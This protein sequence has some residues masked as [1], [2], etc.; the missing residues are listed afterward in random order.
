V[1]KLYGDLFTVPE[2]YIAPVARGDELAGAV[3]K[4]SKSDANTGNYIAVLDSPDTIS[5]KI[6]KAVMDSI[7]G[8]TYEPETRPGVA[9]L[10]TIYV[11][12][13]TRRRRC[14]GALR[15]AGQTPR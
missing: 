7:Q 15:G 12:S 4:M 5:R 9:N 3:E 11:R 8:I 14:G 13:P 2:A 6:R 1:N 10:L